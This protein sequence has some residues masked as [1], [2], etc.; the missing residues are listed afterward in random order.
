MTTIIINEGFTSRTSKT[1]RTRTTIEVKATP[2]VHD[3]DPKELGRDVADAIAKHFRDRIEGITAKASPATLKRREYA[4]RATGVP[5]IS[6]RYSGGRIGSM[7]PNQSDRL[8][9]DSGRFAKS[10]VARAVQDR[11]IINCAANRL[12][13]REFTPAAFQ[14]MLE[15]LKVHV[16]EIAN[17]H[18]LRDSLPVQR[19]IRDSLSD[20]I[21]KSRER[22]GDLK[23]QRARALLG[24]GRS[25]LGL[26]G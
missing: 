9:N 22:I 1:G 6:R 21:K 12:D 23:V 15:Q 26:V 18:L 24:L 19:A 2:I 20:R 11:Y 5:S 16:P 10:I 4:A 3:L 14:R 25:A 7:P 13:Q 17:P 8:F